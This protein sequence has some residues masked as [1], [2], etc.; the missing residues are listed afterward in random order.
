MKTQREMPLILKLLL[1][2]M[3]YPKSQWQTIKSQSQLFFFPLD[4]I[5]VCAY[6]HVRQLSR[7]ENPYRL[8]HGSCFH[9]A[10]LFPLWSGHSGIWPQTYIH[11][12]VTGWFITCY[13]HSHNCL[14]NCKTSNEAWHL[15]GNKIHT[16]TRHTNTH[17]EKWCHR[18]TSISKC[19]CPGTR[20]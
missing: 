8:G 1:H 5:L 10:L 19:L 9:V 14:V 17:L 7:K 15:S 6:K 18:I 4:T 2:F 13:P 12:Q 16:H 11:T 3:K 20:F